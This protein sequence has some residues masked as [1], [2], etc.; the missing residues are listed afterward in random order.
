LSFKR[1]RQLTWGGEGKLSYSIATAIGHSG[2]GGGGGGGLG[3]HNYL[4]I[5]LIWIRIR[6]KGQL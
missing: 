6:E 2:L 5:K 3:L 1:H 4:L